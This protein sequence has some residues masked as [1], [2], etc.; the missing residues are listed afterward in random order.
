MSDLP[1]PTSAT[2][3]GQPPILEILT[4]PTTGQ[5]P[6]GVSR[7]DAQL[8]SSSRGPIRTNS[9]SSMSRLRSRLRDMP[10]PTIEIV[11]TYPADFPQDREAISSDR[12]ALL[13]WFGRQSRRYRGVWVL[14]FQDR[15]A[16]HYHI[17]IDQ[18]LEKKHLVGLHKFW[19]RRTGSPT[20]N[21]VEVLPIEGRER[22]LGYLADLDKEQKALPDWL[23]GSCGRGWA[24]FGNSGTSPGL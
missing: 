13:R 18:R 6:G 9:P 22:T 3:D 20:G 14:E 17:L 15:T 5:N 12:K 10:M 19:Q 8:N 7:Q 23:D 4:P 2:P 16:P 21:G 11:L 1:T 24:M